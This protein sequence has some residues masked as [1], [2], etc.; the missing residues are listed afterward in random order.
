MYPTSELEVCKPDYL[1]V[2]PWNFEKE[3]VE[4]TSYIFEWGVKNIIPTNK[5]RIISQG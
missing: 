2:L 3:I 5:I 1:V 4:K